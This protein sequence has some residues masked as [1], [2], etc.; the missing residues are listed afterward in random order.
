MSTIIK[1][2]ADWCMY[3]NLMAPEWDKMKLLL[4]K[5]KMNN[6][7]DILEIE[8][9]NIGMLDVFNKNHK[10]TNV[11]LNKYP[12]IAKYENG[13]VQYYKD[14]REAK[15]MLNWALKKPSKYTNKKHKKHNKKFKNR[16]LKN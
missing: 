6:K 5:K 1:I 7:P 4:D 9:Q 2:Y 15:K 3:C 11:K 8:S 12:T 14:E 16:T 13:K 10:G